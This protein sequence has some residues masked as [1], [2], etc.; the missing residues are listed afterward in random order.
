MKKRLVFSFLWCS[1]G[2]AQ[3][4]VS[5][6]VNPDGTH[7]VVHQNGNTG[8]IVNPDGTHSTLTQNGNTAIIVNSNGTHSIIPATNTNTMILVNPNGTHSIIQRTG[9]MTTVTSPEGAYT[10]TEPVA[11]DSTRQPFWH[12]LLGKQKK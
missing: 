4:Q 1:I 12:W 6:V 10:I 5:V 7:S 9:S 2:I 11:A 8:V 3:A